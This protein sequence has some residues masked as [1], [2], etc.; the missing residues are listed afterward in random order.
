MTG[1][2]WMHAGRQ[3][4]GKAAPVARCSTATR[5]PSAARLCSSES[6]VSELSPALLPALAS[7]AACRTSRLTSAA[8]LHVCQIAL[9]SPRFHSLKA[10][11]LVNDAAVGCSPHIAPHLPK[12]AVT[13]P[14]PLCKG[15]EAAH[16][17]IWS[18][19]THSKGL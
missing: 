11:L 2:E 10:C 8:A 5:V 7:S 14:P 15:L 3:Q 16:V 4:R 1:D 13:L 19:V 6:D 9:I 12:V 18:F 17:R